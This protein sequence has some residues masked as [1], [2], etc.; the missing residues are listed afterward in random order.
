MNDS[1]GKLLKNF[2]FVLLFANI[3]CCTFFCSCV[4]Q[5][6]EQNPDYLPLDDSDYPYAG[7]PRIVIETENFAQ[8]RN[9]ETNVPAWLQLYDNE[10]PLSE[11]I[12][13]TIRGKGSSSFTM[14]KC[15]FKIELNE[16]YNFFQMPANRD[17]DLI[18]N[19]RDKSFL[20]NALTFELAS[21]LNDEYVPKYHFVELFLNHQYQGV[22]ML[23]EH[24]KV[25]KNRINISQDQFSFFIEK[26]THPDENDVFFQSYLNNTFK[27]HYPKD[28]SQ[29]V[30][31]QIRDSVNT[32]EK[33]LESKGADL[34]SRINVHDFIR[35]Y[36]I[37]EFSKNID[38]A[39]GRSI[40]ITWE[41]GDKFHMGPVW[42]FDLAYGIGNT[43]MMSPC[44]WYVR[45]QGW[46]KY[47]FINQ[48]FKK[49]AQ[50]YWIENHK[51]FENIQN[52]IP[53][54]QKDLQKAVLNDEKRW[55]ILENDKNWP[56]V[57]AYSSYED[58]VDSLKYWI[59]ARADWI[60]SHL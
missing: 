10:V 27:I 22:Y 39:F 35:Y 28:P 1:R 47:L 42:D 40:Y 17:W 13:L 15:S 16:K 55:P 44:D 14:A 3:I 51:I 24:M 12:K 41:T 34:E 5:S 60:S 32:F 30:I 8:I 56:F 29:Q 49:E 38:G 50:K 59:K 48:S 57:E 20:R 58:A 18:S 6:T 53:K 25:G 36:W 23:T 33:Q 4:W 54:L 2:S 31:T 11:P 19:F 45:N 52:F 9:K 7:L 26:T 43:S 21:N 37:Q 46:Y